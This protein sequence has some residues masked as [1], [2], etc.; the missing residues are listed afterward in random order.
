MLLLPRPPLHWGY[1]LVE[2][3]IVTAQSFVWPFLV[4]PPGCK[5]LQWAPC[6]I[7]RRPTKGAALSCCDV[8]EQLLGV[9]V[10]RVCLVNQSIVPF[11][12]RK[13][14]PVTSPQEVGQ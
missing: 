13:T 11:E 9:N 8:G 5:S 14:L 6:A 10:Q 4:V 12:D 7:S 2:Q 1:S 3:F